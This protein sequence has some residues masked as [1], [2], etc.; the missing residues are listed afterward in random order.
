[1]TERAPGGYQMTWRNVDPRLSFL[2]LQTAARAQ[3]LDAID[4]EGLRAAG[5]I[6]Y[7]RDATSLTA[8]VTVAPLIDPVDVRPWETQDAY[9]AE[10]L[11]TLAA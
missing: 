9:A 8:T 6:V 3:I 1:M 2:V 10:L 5:P 11:D 7:Q 4:A